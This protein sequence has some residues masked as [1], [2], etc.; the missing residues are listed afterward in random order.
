MPSAKKLPAS[1]ASASLVGIIMGSKSD[2]ETLQHADEILAKFAVPHEC[3]VV[4]AHRT[5]ELMAEYA[6]SAESRGLKILIAGAGGAAHLPGM[7]AAHTLLPVL[8]VP[9][10]S[11][12]LSGVD[13]ILSIAQMPAGVPVGTLAIGK[14]GAINAALLAVSILATTREDLRK[15]LA[16]FRAEQTAKVL[17]EKLP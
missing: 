13:S 3:R 11:S 16:D 6:K 17:S 12:M 5:P 7:V 15:K 10:Q 8:G 14:A 4:S 2:W 1:N 9:V